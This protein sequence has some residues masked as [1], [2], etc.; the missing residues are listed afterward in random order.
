[1]VFSGAIAIVVDTQSSYGIAVV[2]AMSITYTP[3]PGCF[4]LDDV[5]TSSASLI[6]EMSDDPRHMV[7]E[8]ERD[9]GSV[10]EPVSRQ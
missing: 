6:L 7:S 8:L 10:K 3:T 2:T 5:T 1:M 4:E 9:E